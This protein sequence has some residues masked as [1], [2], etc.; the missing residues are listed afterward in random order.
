M[1]VLYFSIPSGRISV[2]N[3]HS[4]PPTHQ[5]IKG[6]ITQDI[7][8]Y[9]LLVVM[10]VGHGRWKEGGREGIGLVDAGGKVLKTDRKLL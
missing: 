10:S 6:R 2:E 3:I 5:D 1:F 9:I 4:H 7:C 8:W